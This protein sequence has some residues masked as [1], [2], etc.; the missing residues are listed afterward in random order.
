[1][2]KMISIL[3]ACAV[4]LSVSP[5]S[6]FAAGGDDN[7]TGGDGNTQGA[8]SGWGWYNTS[9]YLW[10]VTLYAGKT[11]RVTKQDSLMSDYHKIGTCIMK[12]TGWSIPED[13]RFGNRPKAEYYAGSSMKR[14]TDVAILEDANCPAVPIACGGNLST[15]KSYFGSTGTIKTILTFI[16]RMNGTTPDGY[17]YEFPITINGKTGTEWSYS[18]LEPN[19][20][21]N[22]IPW[23]I[24]YEPMVI[25][26]LKDKTT[27]LAFTATEFAISQM[28]GWYNWKSTGTNAQNVTRLTSKH[29]PTSVQLEESWFGYEV[30]NVTDDS[31]AWTDENIVK[32]GG[33]GMRW[34]NPAIPPEPEAEKDWG[35]VIKSVTPAPG[36]TACNR[37]VTVIWR[38]Y[39]DVKGTVL[40]EY[41]RDGK[42]VWS[43]NK[44][45][46]GI[47]AEQSVFTEYFEGE[48][49]VTFTARINYAHRAEETSSNDNSFSRTVTPRE[50]KTYDFSVTEPDIS[51]KV[52]Y[53]GSDCMVSF[54]SINHN[55]DKSYTNIPVEVLLDGEVKESILT[56]YGP[57]Q[58]YTHEIRLHLSGKA[59]MRNISVRVNWPDRQ[60]ESNASNNI[61]SVSENAPDYYD[62]SLYGLKL[63]A[64]EIPADGEVTLSFSTDSKDIFNK[65]TD[66]PINIYADG[67]EIYSGT[68]DYG[69]GSAVKHT[70][71]FNV[72]QTAGK[73]TLTAGVNIANKN[74]EIYPDNNIK[75]ISFTVVNVNSLGL[76]AVEPNADY[77]EGKD[78]V[79]SY[80][81]FNNSPVDVITDTGCSVNFKVINAKG[82]EIYTAVKSKAVVPMYGTNIVYFKWH[83]PE[84]SAGSSF[85]CIATVN[86]GSFA[87]TDE[88]DNSDTLTR[89]IAEDIYSSVPD[90]IYER[91]KP[92]GFTV[93]KTPDTSTGAAVWTEWTYANGKYTEKTYGLCVSD[94][95]PS[96]KPDTDSPSAVAE[97]GSMTM[98]SGY[99]VTLTWAPL[100]KNVTGYSKPGSSAYT[101][102]QTAYALIPE[103]GFE[104]ENDRFRSL[105]NVN[106]IF[107]FEKNDADRAKNRLHFTPIWYPDGKYEMSVTAL[108]FWTPAGMSET[109]RTTKTVQI[110]DTAYADRVL[111]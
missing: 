20:A 33:W 79:T 42:L 37:D 94:S 15:V 9:Q 12:K 43:G 11:D 5:C 25:M 40:C 80:V 41:L 61:A 60:K 31:H 35:C 13:T 28:N 98:G 1:M 68:A 2:K 10:K 100:V 88:K 70:V 45:F 108:D 71:T 57:G 90:T 62:F 54:R 30:F 48:N 46:D 16:A 56:D 104:F 23:V 34:M 14:L 102:V 105:D 109:V 19:A 86:T 83:I 75:S 18:M 101:S 53:R 63:S 77:R 51:P 52:L 38:N 39:K 65:Y 74:K 110:S 78:V 4:L 99:G 82:E 107:C 36:Y 85:S 73:F 32:G 64:T 22:R 95:I 27:K 29:L 106:D 76:A 93:P 96:L 87:D 55:A 103:F 3:L 8:E 111:Y 69:Y 91:E 67:K 72:G 6:V 81:L 59:G 7:A 47:S 26:N 92:K 84:D 50:D 97:G 44:T 21:T 58:S 17:M 66:I 49:T 24:V 89:I